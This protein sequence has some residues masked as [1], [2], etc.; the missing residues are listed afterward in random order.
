[1]TTATLF[2]D[3]EEHTIFRIILLRAMRNTIQ[4][5]P[6]FLSSEKRLLH[7]AER[8]VY[9]NDI[10]MLKETLEYIEKK[11]DLEDV[12]FL[13][14][15]AIM[16]FPNRFLP[17]LV[18]RKIETLSAFANTPLEDLRSL[19]TEHGESMSFLL[20]RLHHHLNDTEPE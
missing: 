8:G 2:P 7:S 16:L 4:E 15:S 19:F 3:H 5:G 9:M 13:H 6:H 10:R 20:E 14:F 11:Q 1:M 12:S 18:E 17:V